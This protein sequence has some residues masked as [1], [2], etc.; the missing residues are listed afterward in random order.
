MS[1]PNIS[2]VIDRVIEVLRDDL[3]LRREDFELQ[4]LDRP[5]FVPVTVKCHQ[6]VPTYMGCSAR[7]IV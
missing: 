6:Q 3:I 2:V 4:V 1:C 7:G 5:G